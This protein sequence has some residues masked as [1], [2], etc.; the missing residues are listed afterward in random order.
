MLSENENNSLE[1]LYSHYQDSFDKILSKEKSRDRLFFL[2]VFLLGLI[3]V[4]L[5]YSIELLS[6][7][8]ELNFIGLKIKLNQLPLPVILSTTWTIFFGILLRYYQITLDIEKKYSYLHKL[9]SMI[10]KKIGEKKL[11]DRE[12]TSYLTN[13]GKGFRYWTWLFYTAAFP[14]MILI[15]VGASIWTE[16]NSSEIQLEN[17][18]YDLVLSIF[19]LG[20]VFLYLIGVWLKR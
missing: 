9:E 15:V 2:V 12:S 18:I 4:E 5:K 7:I 3:V 13:K 17:R 10:S 6:A 19:I 11:F 16:L 20:T 8:S 14:G 1:I